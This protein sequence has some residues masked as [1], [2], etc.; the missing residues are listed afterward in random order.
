MTI[1]V[2]EF[3]NQGIEQGRQSL[4]EVNLGI[5]NKKFGKLDSS[6]ESKIEKLSIEQLKKLGLSVF[7]FEKIGDLK[8]WMKDN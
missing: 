2:K 8:I 7:D 6:I 4:L 3:I 1:A 5:L